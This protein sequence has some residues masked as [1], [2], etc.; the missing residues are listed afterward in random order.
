M[1]PQTL[2]FPIVTKSNFL[3]EVAD[4]PELKLGCKVWEKCPK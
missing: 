2:A 4:I 1:C 3:N